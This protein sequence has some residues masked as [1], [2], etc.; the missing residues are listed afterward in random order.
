MTASRTRRHMHNFRKLYRRG[1]SGQ[2][3]SLTNESFFFRLFSGVQV[4]SFDTLPRKMRHYTSFCLLGVRNMK[5]CPLS[6]TKK[7]KKLGLGWRSTEKYS[8]PNSETVSYIRLKL[9]TAI[10][11]PS[12]IT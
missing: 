9:G 3:A 12:I 8:R 7:L 11:R 5:I 10:D 4:A 2:V 1:W 6:A